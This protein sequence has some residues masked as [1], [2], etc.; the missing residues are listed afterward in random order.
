MNSFGGEATAS[1]NSKK[2][3]QLYLSNSRN[4][5]PYTWV[6]IWLILRGRQVALKSRLY[7]GNSPNAFEM[8][9]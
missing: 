7:Q 2:I 9:G 4:A 1:Q 3:E 6:K 5:I 8:I